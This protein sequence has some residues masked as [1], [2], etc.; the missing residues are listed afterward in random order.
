VYQRPARD[1]NYEFWGDQVFFGQNPPQAARIS[2]HLAKAASDVKLLI[3]D[4]SGRQVREISGDVLKASKGEGLNVACWDLRVQPLQP[5]P[6][7]GPRG[8]SPTGGSG[9]VAGQGSPFGAGCATAGGGF[10]G[11]LG[12]ASTAGPF[13]LPGTYTVSLVLEGSA[14]DTKPLKVVADP[15]VALDA[16]QRRKMFDMAMEM[17][18][19]Q[20]R[21]AEA[22]SSLRQVNTKAGE[23][24]KEI[25]S[26]T[27]LPLEIRTSIETFSKETASTLPKL[28]ATGGGRGGPGGGG[29][30]VPPTAIVRLAQAKSAMMGGMWPTAQSL[31]AYEEARKG[32]P[33]AIAEANELIVRA[34]ALNKALAAHNLTLGTTTAVK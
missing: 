17:H 26:R 31:A 10:G 24:V 34:G 12:G 5:P 15:Q 11:A 19:L 2:W 23:L 16:A 18:D 25:A 4:G 20:R 32:V 8:G 9:T 7:A 14:V 1:R 6:G 28:A 22:A 30:G 13:V 3:A 27:D 21:A 33:A 29:A